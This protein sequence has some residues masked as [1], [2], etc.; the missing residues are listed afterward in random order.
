MLQICKL[1]QKILHAI[2]RRMVYSM[3]GNEQYLKSQ[4]GKIG[5]F[6]CILVISPDFPD[7]VAKNGG[8][9]LSNWHEKLQ[10]FTTRWRCSIFTHIQIEEILFKFINYSKYLH[11]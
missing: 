3:S 5:R 1:A 11:I 10:I 9:G 8:R 6:S 7:F 4:F 2:L